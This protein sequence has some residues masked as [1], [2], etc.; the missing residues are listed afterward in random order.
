[1]AYHESKWVSICTTHAMHDLI[2]VYVCS[3]TTIVC[4]KKYAN[5]ILKES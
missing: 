4:Y 3:V 5:K 1:M 2:G